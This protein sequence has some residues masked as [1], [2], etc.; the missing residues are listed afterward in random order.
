[1]NN[2]DFLHQLP[3]L[4]KELPFAI[5]VCDTHGIIL[6]MNERSILT[7]AKYGG[8]ALIGSSLFGC[9]PEPAA[10]KLREMLEKGSSNVYTI[11][12]NGTRKMIYQSP[13]FTNRIYEGF[14]ELSLELPAGVPHF[15]RST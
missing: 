4:T 3:A 6:Y 7:F 11:E 13:W 15:V 5:T 14:I 8:E 2:H 12:K 1:M 10:T 9:H